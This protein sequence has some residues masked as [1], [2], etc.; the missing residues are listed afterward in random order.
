MKYLQRV[1]AWATSR[2]GAHDLAA[3]AAAVVAFYK[4]LQE[5]G[6]LG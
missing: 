6:L 3:F 2:Q 5:A 1:A 4:V